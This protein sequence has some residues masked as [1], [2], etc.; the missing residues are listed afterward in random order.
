MTRVSL[1]AML[2]GLGAC[3]T[4]VGYQ[5]KLARWL[6]ADEVEL[7]RSW[8]PPTRTYQTGGHRFM[9]FESRRDVYVPEVPSYFSTTTKGTRSYT[10]FNPGSPAT[11]LTSRCTTTFELVNAK[12]TS[13]AFDGDDCRAQQ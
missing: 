10:T 8:G 7:V 11:T 1:L 4:P 12:V 13:Y 9:T 5:K 2:L 3:A 6:G